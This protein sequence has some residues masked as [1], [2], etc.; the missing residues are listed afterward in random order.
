MFA[1]KGRLKVALMVVGFLVVGFGMYGAVQVREAKA[2]SPYYCG[3]YHGLQ[4]RPDS[5]NPYKSSS[6]TQ[7]SQRTITGTCSV[8]GG[9]AKLTSW[10]ERYESKTE[11]KYEHFLD[12][13]GYYGWTYCHSHSKVSARYGWSPPSSKC[14][15]PDCGG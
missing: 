14:E 1:T 10:R 2:H 12:L 15:D 13:L 8:C 11:K 7:L 6:I 3:W 5:N 9:S 4:H